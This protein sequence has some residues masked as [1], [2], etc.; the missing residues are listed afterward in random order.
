MKI[1]IRKHLPLLIGLLVTLA[2]LA[3]QAQRKSPLA[4]A[5]AIRK[6]LELRESRL[7]FGAGL[8]STVNQD[9]YHTMFANVKLGF[10]ITDW[11]SISGFADFAVA[12][13]STGFR[14]RVLE[15]LV[16]PPTVARQPSNGEARAAMSQINQMFGGQL[17][18]TPFTGKY[19]LFGKLFA[20]YDFYG[21]LGLGA[22]NLAPTNAAAVPCNGTQFG[23]CPVSGV[24]LGP[25]VGVGLHTFFNQWL[26]LNVELRDI[27]AQ[28]N[29]AGR[30]V[31]GDGVANSSDLTWSSTFSVL[32]SLVV[33]LPTVADISP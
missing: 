19:S 9:F 15:S 18:F 26:A 4:D 24:K 22:I 17:E 28:L 33:Y 25:E 1:W 10:H 31:N 6:R 30:D 29:P 8:G 13:I 5:P 20:H 3:A 27:V 23:S 21:F 16:D 11:L 32:A 2:P 14:D 12:N 7:E